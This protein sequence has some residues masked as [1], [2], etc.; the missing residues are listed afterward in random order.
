MKTKTYY[1]YDKNGFFISIGEAKNSPKHEEI[2]QEWYMSPANSTFTALPNFNA[3][4]EIPK[5]YNNQWVVA[6]LQESGVF[7][8]KTDAT[9]FTEIAKKD[10][11]LYTQIEPLQKYDDGTTQAFNDATQ[12]WEYTF[13]GKDLIEAERL[14]ALEA[15]FNKSKK[16]TLKNGRTVII[17][18][19]TPEREF[20]LKIV[21]G[22]SNVSS[23]E[24]AAF[25]YE[26]QTDAGKLALRILPEIAAYI[27]K[28]L[29]IATLANPQ[30]TK[31]N[32]RV[33]NKT[34]VYELALEKINKAST[35]AELDVVTW[36]FIN[37]TGIVIDVNDK[38]AEML[39]DPTVTDFAKAAIKD[40]KDPTT[41]E[42]HLVKTLQELASDS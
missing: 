7:Y 38:A 31:V 10:V 37:P 27:F 19:D 32:S 42:I 28:D 9:E 2:G 22:V 13:Q 6:D 11:N 39:A 34:T 25:I 16:I 5:F 29:F 41:G 21:E 20:F 33:H 30:Q 40:A 36:S 4:L 24:G 17:E 3:E 12:I 14:E 15:D 23:T 26:Q 18:H 8:L 35:Q 1:N